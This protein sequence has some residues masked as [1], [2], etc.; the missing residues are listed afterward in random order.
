MLKKSTEKEIWKPVI[1]YENL[2]EVS[3]LG[4]IRS[5]ERYVKI[6]NNKR[7]L[8]KEKILN[9]IPEQDG[10]HRIQLHLNGKCV[11]K[12]VHSLVMESF[13]GPC[14][15]GQQVMHLEH[16]KESGNDRLSNLRYGSPSCNAAFK[17]DD[18]TAVCGEISP[19][20]KLTTKDVIAIRFAYKN[21]LYTQTE[22]APLFN[23]GRTTICAAIRGQNWGHL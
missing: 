17:H 6:K 3:D 9:R 21:K 19:L 18:G 7:R 15:E 11:N 12:Y 16:V 20:S 23:V 1:G 14:P 2:Y 4:R 13:V 22:L 8:K 10:Y 5:L